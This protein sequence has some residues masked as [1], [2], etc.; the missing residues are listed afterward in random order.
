MNRLVLLSARALA[1][2]LVVVP[3]AL[4][5]VYL[6]VIATDRY[7]SES[8]VSVRQSSSDGGAI[9]GAA[10]LLA[11]INPPSHA[12]TLLLRDFVHSQALLVQLESQLQLRAHFAEVGADWPFRLAPDA[13][14]EDFVDY[15]RDRIEVAFDDRSSLLRLRVQGLDPDYAQRLNAAIL[16]ASERF[17]NETSH[18]IARERLA[19]AEG[20]LDRAGA[21]LQ[22]AAADVL[23]FQSRNRLL[24]PTF[25][26]QAS[27]NLTAE[28]EA[29]RSR[30]EAEL[31]G[32]RAF[33]NDGAYQVVAL[34]NQIAAL[35]RQIDAERKRATGGD[36]KDPRLN[37]LALDFQGLQLQAEFARDAYKLALGA[38][39]NAR[40]DATRKIKSL[41][42]LEPPSRPQTA[43]YPHVAYNLGTL[44][45]VCLLLY[46][47]ARLV[48]A[49]IREHQD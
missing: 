43:E 8:A 29:S 26:A 28:L 41:V 40:I 39:E 47:I 16:E 22:A 37:K 4:Y 7:V 32:L 2:V 6:G 19:F 30:L 45:A 12:D 33:L 36:A 11:G 3:V 1:V 25:Q 23:A 38:V 18:R 20:E 14:L 49:T 17:V 9:P 21:R 27:G 48:L 13:T 34:K 15:M 5:A 44:L 35:N 31:G 10:M 24:D 42:V 46:A